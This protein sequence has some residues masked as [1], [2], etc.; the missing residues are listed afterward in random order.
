MRK[1]IILTAVLMLTGSA[2]GC[3]CCNWLWRGA[4]CG[5]WGSPTY[6]D[7]CPPANPCDPCGTSGEI[8]PGSV[9]YSSIPGPQ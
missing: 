5:P 6:S 9:P 4:G 3:R 1:L 2:V 8:A 7:Y